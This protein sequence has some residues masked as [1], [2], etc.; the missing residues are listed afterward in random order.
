MSIVSLTSFAVFPMAS[1]T[2]FLVSLLCFLFYVLNYAIFLHYNVCIFL[3]ASS[4][5]TFHCFICLLFFHIHLF[6]C[7]LFFFVSI[8][9]FFCCIL[10]SISW[11]CS[12]IVL[13]LTTTSFCYLICFLF[14]SCCTKFPPYSFV[15][16]FSHVLPNYLH[17]KLHLV[18]LQSLQVLYPFCLFLFYIFLFPSGPPPG[19]P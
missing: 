3:T 11:V 14:L 1:V 18:Q 12:T 15:F 10:S 16:C 8:S 4:L 9:S 17:F 5:H 2:Y 6:I 7:L 19:L 13:A